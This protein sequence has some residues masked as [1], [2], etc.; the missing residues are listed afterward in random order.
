MIEEKEQEGD[1]KVGSLQLLNALKAKL[2]P[3]TPQSKGLMY[4]EALVN[5]K[6]TKALVDTSATHDFVSED[7]ARRLELQASIGRRMAQGSQF[8]CQAITW[9][10]SRDDYAHR[11]VER[12]G[13]LHSGT[14]GRLQD[15]TRDGFPTK[16][17]G[18]ATT[19][20]TLNGYPI[21]GEAMH[22]PYGHRRY[23]QDPYVISYAS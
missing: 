12:K 22:G 4:V 23:A 2:M 20:P 9:S 10:S 18:R 11:L 5:G 17:Q 6:T 19:F 15:G 7:E 14:H 1:V 8:S 21:G 16:G 13:R 3:R